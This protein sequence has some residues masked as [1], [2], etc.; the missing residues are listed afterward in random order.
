MSDVGVVDAL[1]GLQ[2]LIE[3]DGGAFEYLGYESA[4]GVISLRLTLDNV[5]CPECILPPEMLRQIASDF[6]RR[7]VPGVTLV[8]IEDPREAGLSS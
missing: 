5:T 1:R 7:S 2:E 8:K 4:E 3:A 6:M